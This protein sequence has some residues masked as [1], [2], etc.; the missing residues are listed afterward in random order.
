MQS[1]RNGRGELSYS[2]WKVCRFSEDI[3]DPFLQEVH[4]ASVNWTFD[5]F[6]TL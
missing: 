4:D 2:H 5:F 6:L 1:S 3:K